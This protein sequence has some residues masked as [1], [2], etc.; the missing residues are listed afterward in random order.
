L[1]GKGG[2]GKSL[3]ACLLAQYLPEKS[4]NVRSYDADPV[5]SIFASFAAL[6]AAR[7]I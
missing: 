4:I 1:Q 3:A 6:A 2:I 5:N 7:S